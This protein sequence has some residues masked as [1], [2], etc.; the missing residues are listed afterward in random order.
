MSEIL[1]QYQRISPA[2]W[3]YV[4]SL[5]TIGLF[6]K[7]SRFW[8]VRNL[9]L[10]LLILLAPGL[11]MVVQ[12]ET[13]QRTPPADVPAGTFNGTPEPFVGASPRESAWI[14][15]TSL[16]AVAAEEGERSTDDLSD[17]SEDQAPPLDVPIVELEAEDSP[18]GSLLD[19][20]PKLPDHV[21]QGQRREALGYIWLFS[22]GALLLVRMLI[23]P[24]MVRRPL[25]EPNLTS[26]GLIFIGCSLF[27]FLMANVI[28]GKP[29]PDDLRGP[30]AAANLIARRDTS[31]DADTMPKYGPGLAWVY[32]LP[33]I[34]TTA[35]VEPP[36]DLELPEQREYAWAVAAKIV[37]ILSHLAIVI[38]MV[39]IGYRHFDNLR[40]GIGAAALYLMLPY[41]AE[42]T[43][44]VDHALPAALLVWA[45]VFYRQ[46]LVAG[47]FLGLASGVIYYPLFLLPLWV[48]FYWQ[49]GLARF[50]A[51]VLAMMSIVALSLIFTSSDL[52]SFWLQFKAMFGIRDPAMTDL[53]GI[54][55]VAWDPAYRVPILAAFIAL[56]GTLALWPPRKNLGTLLSCSGAIMLAAQFWH[57]YGGGT[58][59][60]WYL[61]LV[62][63]TVFRP[64]LEDRVAI[65]VLDKGRWPRLAN[66]SR[67]A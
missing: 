57:G 14:A 33:T 62:L 61:P 67:A 9:D 34:S 39:V 5:L 38:G 10:V 1:F 58:F 27:V 11:L 53:Q 42:M 41:M 48:S 28:N 49:R 15:L 18:T 3:V 52:A 51:G 30:E 54:W 46:P 13:M 50:A 7:F 47:M 55:R 17:A 6:F 45:I 25:L 21:I 26:G 23:D 36:A 19:D 2:T 29:T 40:M 31:G 24:N 66:M 43:G 64:N 60:A 44:R 16:T 22:I 63:L 56:S 8:S 20:E 32:A 65:A 59:M 37:A 4:S 12:G 35:L